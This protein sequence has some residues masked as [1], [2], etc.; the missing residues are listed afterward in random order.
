MQIK[1]IKEGRWYQTTNGFGICTKV[2]GTFPPSVR[3][4]IKG[5]IPFGLRILK[6][7]DVQE[8]IPDPTAKE[9]SDAD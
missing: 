7:R 8:E 3:I 6:P 5:P 4:D 9:K 1:K 2:G